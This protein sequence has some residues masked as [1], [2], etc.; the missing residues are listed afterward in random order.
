MW[1]HNLLP[2]SSFL[3]SQFRVLTVFFLLV[4]FVNKKDTALVLLLKKGAAYCKGTC[5]TFSSNIITHTSRAWHFLTFSHC[6][7]SVHH[8]TLTA[9]LIV[10]CCGLREKEQNISVSYLTNVVWDAREGHWCCVYTAL[11]RSALW[12][13]C[14]F[15][16]NPVNK[17]KCKNKR[18]QT[19]LAFTYCFSKNSMST[20]FI[21]QHF[22]VIMFNSWD[23]EFIMW[24]CKAGDWER[25]RGQESRREK[26]V[27]APVGT[28]LKG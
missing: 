9:A 28:G 16:V 1:K 25:G 6:F 19:C 18:S 4:F 3:I 27:L 23:Y 24:I 2:V 8:H 22:S 10:S 12:V 14:Y 20:L 13:F 5:H 11:I 15:H 17:V 21:L 26:N 7:F